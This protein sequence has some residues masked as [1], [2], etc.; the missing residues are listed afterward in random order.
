MKGTLLNTATV[1]VGATLGLLLKSRVPEALNPVVLSGMAL[2][3]VGLS[4]KMALSG[5]NPLLPA[6]GMALGGILGTVLGIQVGLEGLA[7]TIKVAT[8]SNESKFVEGL[9]STSVLFCIGPMTLLGCI[10]DGLEGRSDILNLKSTL[11][12]FSAFFFAVGSGA[13]VLVTA[14]VVLIVQGAITLLA[15]YLRGVAKDEELMGTLTATGGAILLGIS[16]NMLGLTKL[17]MANYAPALVIAPLGGWV[18]GKL[19]K[20]K[21][22]PPS[23]RLT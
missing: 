12:G 13:G 15:R 17:P 5:K 1:A 21:P 6:V 23:P 10:E 14:A 4:I 3:V 16:L 11:D 20:V 7:E 22:T 8:G 2:V 19:A 9:V 18:G